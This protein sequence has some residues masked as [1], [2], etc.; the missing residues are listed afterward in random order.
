MLTPTKWPFG[1]P[2]SR[3]N[4]SNFLWFNL[5]HL[6]CFFSPARDDL[7]MNLNREVTH[8]LES[9]HP[10][11]GH[12]RSCLPTMLACWQAP[13]SVLSLLRRSQAPAAWGIGT[14]GLLW[15]GGTELCEYWKEQ[16]RRRWTGRGSV[17][18]F[19]KWESW[20]S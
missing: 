10:R 7:K 9:R 2:K 3:S 17:L 20:A 5:K 16:N 15:V 1:S 6:R 12:C 8:S 13:P 14:R 18:R 4:H 19:H 11:R